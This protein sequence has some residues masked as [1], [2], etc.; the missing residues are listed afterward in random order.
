MIIALMKVVMARWFL[1]KEEDG[2]GKEKA[3]PLLVEE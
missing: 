3:R 2:D 1:K